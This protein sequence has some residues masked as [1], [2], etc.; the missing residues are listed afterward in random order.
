MQNSS[1]TAQR[2]AHG[3]RLCTSRPCRHPRKAGP[4]RGVNPADVFQSGRPAYGKKEGLRTGKEKNRIENLRPSPPSGPA[5]GKKEN[6]PIYKFL[7][8]PLIRKFGKDWYA[9]LELVAEELDK[10]HML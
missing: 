7:K 10:Q 1:K 5:D 4:F 3:D 6:L 9:E 8:E 2:A